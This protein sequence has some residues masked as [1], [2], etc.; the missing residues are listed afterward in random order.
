MAADGLGEGRSLDSFFH[1]RVVELWPLVQVRMEW[2]MKLENR[3]VDPSTKL[4]WLV[5]PELQPDFD[6]TNPLH[7]EVDRIARQILACRSSV[8]T[9]I[10]AGVSEQKRL[11]VLSDLGAHMFDRREDGE[12]FHPLNPEQQKVVGDYVTHLRLIDKRVHVGVLSCEADVGVIRHNHLHPENKIVTPDQFRASADKIIAA[13]VNKILETSSLNPETTVIALPWRSA[14]AMG[15]EFARRGFH[16]FVHIDAAR[17]EGDLH[18]EVGYVSSEKVR[19]GDTVIIADPM[20]ATGNT[21]VSALKDM[22]F[23][24][25]TNRLI[26]ASVV[27]APEGIFH[28][29]RKFPSMQFFTAALDKCLNKAGFICEGLGD[30]G[31]QY[32]ADLLEAAVEALIVEWTGIGLLKMPSD[33]V[34]LKKRMM[35]NVR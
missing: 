15:A 34:A 21:V 5:K 29:G 30:F 32:F 33:M 13:L 3:P 31:D 17:H 25:S 2:L 26:S 1:P 28:L 27:S 4:E 18:T 22:D 20:L 24:A 19:P 6:L 23:D 12:A 35:R 11:Q 16:R 8:R 7:C 14:L 9:I 10:E